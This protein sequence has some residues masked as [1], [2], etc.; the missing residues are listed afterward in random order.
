MQCRKEYFSL[1]A[2]ICDVSR[3]GRKAFSLWAADLMDC[4][5][6]GMRGVI[7]FRSAVQVHFRAV[8]A[9]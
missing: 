2:S 3:S 6:V 7:H 5:N 1:R 8:A 9:D 4:A